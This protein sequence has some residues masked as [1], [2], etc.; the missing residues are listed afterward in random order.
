M[1]R[2]QPI[3]WTELFNFK[4]TK[5]IFTELN[6]SGILFKKQK[7]NKLKDLKKPHLNVNII[8][9]K[10]VLCKYAVTNEILIT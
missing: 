2:K 5:S 3:D 1:N 9:F 7:L 10:C 4:D 8:S 6:V